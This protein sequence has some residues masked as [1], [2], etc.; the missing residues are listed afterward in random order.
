MIQYPT[1][2]M[3]KIYVIGFKI[4]LDDY[5]QLSRI[6]HLDNEGLRSEYLECKKK[7]TA[8]P[9]YPLS[10]W[11]NMLNSDEIDTENYLWKQIIN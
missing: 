5:N 1:S 4:D 7:G 3:E 11:F 9:M 8:G 6:S 10:L 2:K